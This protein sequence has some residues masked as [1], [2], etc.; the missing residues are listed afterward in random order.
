MLDSVATRCSVGPRKA[1]R[2]P[3]IGRAPHGKGELGLL[4]TDADKSVWCLREYD[5]AVVE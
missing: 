4:S 1:T 2:G 5:D 3:L